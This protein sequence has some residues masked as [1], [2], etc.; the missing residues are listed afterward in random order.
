MKTTIRTRDY[1]LLAAA[2][3]LGI[4]STLRS[5]GI[6]GVT[7]PAAALLGGAVLLALCPLIRLWGDGESSAAR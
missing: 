4:A 3:A 1:W 5:L 6:D 7:L 2:G